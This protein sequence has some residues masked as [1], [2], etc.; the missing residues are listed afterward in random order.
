[1]SKNYRPFDPSSSN[2]RCQTDRFVITFRGDLA[3]VIYGHRLHHAATAARVAT[4]CARAQ[5]W[6]KSPR[7]LPRWMKYVI[8]CNMKCLPKDD[9]ILEPGFVRGWLKMMAYG[10]IYIHIIT[11]IYS[12]YTYTYYVYMYT[13][14]YMHIWWYTFF[15]FNTSKPWIFQENMS[16]TSTG[17]LT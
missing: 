4:P 5:E 17:Y 3:E 2:F 6:Q 8:P 12:V 10:M 7:K 14:T 13:Y 9:P 1:L 11:Y 16:I 15:Y